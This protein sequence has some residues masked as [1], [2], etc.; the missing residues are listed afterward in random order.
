MASLTAFSTALSAIG[1]VAGAAISASQADRAAQMRIEA[2]NREYEMRGRQMKLQHEIEERRRKQ[3]LK[4]ALATR[5]AR[6]G[7]AGIAGGGSSAAVLAGLKRKSAKAGAEAAKEKRLG[8]Q[9]SLLSVEN[10]NRRALQN[11]AFAN[12]SAAFKGSFGLAGSIVDGLKESRKT[13]K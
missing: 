11:A 8:L 13:Q 7:G 2:Q 9:S 10:S 5:R 12:E 1:S 3:E 4:E 6:Y